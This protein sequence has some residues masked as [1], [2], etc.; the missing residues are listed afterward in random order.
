[1]Q[2]ANIRIGNTPPTA[3][4]T[5]SASVGKPGTTVTFDATASNDPDG[6]IYSYKWD[7]EGDGTYLP[8]P[9]FNPHGSTTL[10]KTYSQPGT[11]HPTLMVTDDSGATDTDSQTLTVTLGNF[12]SGT[13]DAEARAGSYC[14]AAVVDGRA[15]VAYMRYEELRYQ[16]ALD[17]EALNW[18]A[19][20]VIDTNCGGYPDLAVV[21]GR[22]AIAY[23][24]GSLDLA[25]VRASDASGASWPTPAIAYAK[26]SKPIGYYPSL[27]VANGSP[28]IVYIGKDIM[29]WG[30]YVWCVRAN[31]VVGSIWLNIATLNPVS[32]S[33]VNPALGMVGG[34]PMVSY[35]CQTAQG[36]RE[37]HAV[38]ATGS[39][40]EGWLNSA[41]TAVSD[42]SYPF[43]QG[44]ALFEANGR[45]AVGYFDAYSDTVKLVRASNAETTEWNEPVTIAQ[46]DG[47]CHA[48]AFLVINGLPCCAFDGDS[49]GL[50]FTIATTVSGAEWN[51]PIVVDAGANPGFISLIAVN[52]LPAF[53]YYDG[54][55]E[56]LKFAIYN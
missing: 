34:M 8:L 13:L 7:P 11:Y 22:P 15:A 3:S 24:S 25:Y 23:Q 43:T 12:Y 50:C 39:T 10:A 47:D 19:I 53:A 45:A 48:S 49:A 55:A 40:G 36:A 35:M 2:L 17:V 54:A 44:H 29:D 32:T 46:V 5:A 52:D 21:A 26:T 56:C 38:R 42:G 20:K 4:F 30:G 33:G 18:S 31:D 1:L 14:S 9:P 41:A 51:P 16:Y 27:G 6:T 28:L 37:L